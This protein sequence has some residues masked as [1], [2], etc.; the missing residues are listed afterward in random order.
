M[1]MENCFQLDTDDFCLWRT[2]QMHK[3]VDFV[4]NQT[5]V[6]DA[7]NLDTSKEQQSLKFFLLERKKR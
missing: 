7:P 5:L 1:F 3:F 2:L 6:K 4:L